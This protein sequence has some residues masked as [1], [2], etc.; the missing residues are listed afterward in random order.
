MGAP[1]HLSIAQGLGG[2][3]HP[4]LGIGESPISWLGCRIPL[5]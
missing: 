1:V 3:S 5:T 2:V 4:G